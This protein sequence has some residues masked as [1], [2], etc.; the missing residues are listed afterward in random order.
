M[1]TTFAQ[2]GQLPICLNTPFIP[3]RQRYANSSRYPKPLRP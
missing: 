2:V 3:L 1:A